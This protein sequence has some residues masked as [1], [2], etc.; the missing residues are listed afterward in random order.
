MNEGIFYAGLLTECQH[1]GLFNLENVHIKIDSSPH[2]HCK[3]FKITY[4]KNGKE[5]HVS[6]GYTL[7][8]I[9]DEA[10]A[11]YMINMFGDTLKARLNGPH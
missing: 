5:W 10:Y 11:T 7:L 3:M 8:E 4:T 1:A 6:N 9:K 2:G